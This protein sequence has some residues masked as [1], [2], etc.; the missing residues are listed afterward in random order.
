MSWSRLAKI[1][2]GVVVLI[3]VGGT[4]AALWSGPAALPE[5]AGYGPDPTLPEPHASW[6]PTLKTAKAVGW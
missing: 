6:I 4:A 5:Q 3:V 1:A 2:V